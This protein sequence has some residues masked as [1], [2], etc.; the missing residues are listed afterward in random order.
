MKVN[1]GHDFPQGTKFMRAED[2]QVFCRMIIGKVEKG[3][4]RII[5]VIPMEQVIYPPIVDVRKQPF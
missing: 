5:D 3:V 2:H 4:R 1:E